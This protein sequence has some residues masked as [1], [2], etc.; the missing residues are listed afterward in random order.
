MRE[1]PIELLKAIAHPLRYAILAALV[2]RELNVGEIEAATGIGQPT[3]SQQ[4]SVLRNA[5]LVGS[6]RES[7][8]VFY[9]LETEPL[10]T[11]IESLEELAPQTAIR[12]AKPG[13]EAGLGGAATFAHLD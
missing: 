10:A 4:L 12:P 1:P 5:G 11:V 3:L 9:S 2:G 6:R 8:L 7:K 13:K